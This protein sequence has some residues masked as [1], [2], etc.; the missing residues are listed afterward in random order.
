[1]NQMKGKIVLITGC[2]D[3]IGQ[4]TAYELALGGAVV[5]LHA[6]DFTKGSAVLRSLIDEV[7][8]ASFDLFIANLA[9]RQEIEQMVNDVRSVYSK[10]DVLI[11]NEAVYLDQRKLTDNTIEK[12][13]SVN[14]LAP[15]LLTHLL[16]PLLKNAGN[17]RIINV[18]SHAHFTAKFDI[19]NLQGEK[20]FDGTKAFCSSKLCN[21][22]FTY[23]L[24]EKLKGFPIS[25]N[26][27]HTGNYQPLASTRLF[28]QFAGQTDED[29]A[30]TIVFLSC[31]DE[32]GKT[33]GM[34]YASRLPVQSSY[35]S[36]SRK[37]QQQLWNASER[38]SLIG[39]YFPLVDSL[40]AKNS[41]PKRSSLKQTLKQAAQ[42]N[43]NH[44]CRRGSSE[45]ILLPGKQLSMGSVNVLTGNYHKLAGQFL[46]SH[47]KQNDENTI[48]FRYHFFGELASR[49]KVI[50][51]SVHLQGMD[52]QNAIVATWFSYAGPAEIIMPSA[53]SKI[54]LLHDFFNAVHYPGDQQV[55][56]EDAV[57]I[58]NDSNKS[59]ETLVQQVVS[60]AVYSMFGS[61]HLLENI[62]LLKDEVNRVFLLNK[63][64]LFYLR[65]FHD[66]SL[67]L[68]YHTGYACT[69]Y[70]EAYKKNANAIE[71]RI[72]KLEDAEKIVVKGSEKSKG[73]SNK[74]NR[75]AEDLFR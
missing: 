65:Y 61:P 64:E 14:H 55:I 12:T 17:A 53:D 34:Y 39:N 50:A 29:G 38:L 25:V 28:G 63:T 62:T 49:A 66:F 4:Q 57:K 68:K 21:L 54:N 42:K 23:S 24:A 45:A 75:E 44:V 67:T 15:F 19:R 56:V 48:L 72:S 11:N 9:N 6:K 16:L 51:K 41:T 8:T 40:T 47:Y 59:A 74:S 5:L 46:K 26:A 30:D 10:L 52:Y 31:S 37:Y 27:V 20:S 36:Y 71:K 1:M 7:P 43:K 58:V 73:A 2:T 22:L 35:N 70:A 3:G 32:A 18:S 33:S 13:F 60:D 69:N